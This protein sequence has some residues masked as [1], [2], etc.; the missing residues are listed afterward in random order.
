[1]PFPQGLRTSYQNIQQ[2]VPQNTHPIPMQLEQD[3]PAP[4]AGNHTA[5]GQYGHTQTRANVPQSREP[6]Y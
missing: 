4:Y 6:A 3:E 2:V 5:Y 1:M